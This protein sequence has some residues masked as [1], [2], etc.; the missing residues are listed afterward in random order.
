MSIKDKL[1]NIF[2]SNKAKS[3]Y[4][5]IASIIVSIGIPLIVT[6][7]KFNLIQEFKQTKTSVKIGLIAAVIVVVLILVFFKRILKFLNSLAFSYTICLLKGILKLIPVILILIILI[8]IASVIDDLIFVLG[9]LLGCN[10]IAFLGIDPFTQ[11]FIHEAK[12]DE[13][14]EVIKEGVESAKQN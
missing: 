6:I 7:S 10:A 1:K 3:I 4:C 14:R 8:S 2:L 12:K 9:W 11:M 5:F 13:Q